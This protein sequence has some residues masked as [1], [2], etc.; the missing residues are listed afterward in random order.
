MVLGD[1]GEFGEEMER[2]ILVRNGKWQMA[3]F[4]LVD[5]KRQVG[6]PELPSKFGG[7]G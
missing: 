2:E 3:C 7:A 1:D 6:Y 5:S 4:L